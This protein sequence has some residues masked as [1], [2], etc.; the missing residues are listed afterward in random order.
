MN[1]STKSTKCLRPGSDERDSCLAGYRISDEVPSWKP[2]IRQPNI[3]L[4]ELRSSGRF[5]RHREYSTKDDAKMQPEFSLSGMP[6]A[7]LLGHACVLF[8]SAAF[9]LE[10]VPPMPTRILDYI[11]RIRWQSY[12]I[13]SSGLSSLWAIDILKFRNIFL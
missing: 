5:G 1:F 13:A 11:L 4:E 7:R 10:A 3:R 6:S 2:D 9:A 8:Y 12:R